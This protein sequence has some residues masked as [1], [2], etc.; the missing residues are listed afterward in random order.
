MM[1][2]RNH[3][4][5]PFMERESSL[6]EYADD[7]INTM[8][9]QKVASFDLIGH[10][11]GGL[12]SMIAALNYPKKI[13]R[14]VVEDVST[15]W[16]QVKSRTDTYFN[17]M[18]AVNDGHISDRK[19]VKDMLLREE[20]NECIVNFLLTNLKQDDSGVFKFNIPTQSLKVDSSDAKRYD[21]NKFKCTDVPALFIKGEKSEY[22]DDTG[23]KACKRIFPNSQLQVIPDCG[24]WI[25]SEKPSEFVA[26]VSEFLN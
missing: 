8:N 21:W 17:V 24:H 2:L 19:L 20:K 23:Y 22:I 13:N 4:K 9:E 18:Q 15:S 10:S 7:A 5:S 1:D 12:V 6:D 14:L 26:A 3:G 16:V 25:H 11:M